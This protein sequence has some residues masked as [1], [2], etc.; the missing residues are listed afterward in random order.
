MQTQRI[1]TDRNDRNDANTQKTHTWNSQGKKILERVS[2]C[3]IKWKRWA[4]AK[5]YAIIWKYITIGIWNKTLT[6][7]LRHL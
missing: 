6:K 7:I 1:E 4:L 2:Y 3:E 5:M